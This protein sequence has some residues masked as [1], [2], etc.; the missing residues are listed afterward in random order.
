MK[1]EVGKRYR[2][3][4]GKEYT[5][6]ALARHSETH[7]E[8]VIYQAEYTTEDFGDKP[9]WARPRAMFEEDI[10]YDGQKIPRFKRID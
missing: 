6:C 8:L 7:E 2:H 5:V 4:K 10:V 3:Y 9:I 1:A